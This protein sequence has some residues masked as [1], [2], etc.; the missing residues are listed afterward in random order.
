MYKGSKQFI[1]TLAITMG[2]G[3]FLAGCG[4]D[5]PTKDAENLVKAPSLMDTWTNECKESEIL[6]LS[7]RKYIEFSGNN[8]V[9]LHEFYS[10]SD[11]QSPAVALT[12]RGTFTLGEKENTGAWT[13]DSTFNTA[14]VTALNAFGQKVLETAKFCGI[15][16][17][18][19]NQ[20]MTVGNQENCP[21]KSV[22]SIEFN[23]ALVE[24]DKLYLGNSSLTN[25]VRNP[26]ERPNIERDNVMTAIDRNL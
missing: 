3:L 16:T 7:T 18:P 2:V 4:E 23:R 8:F 1:K 17:W 14:Q 12:Y 10:K 22:P 19:I 5:S 9:Q 24:S 15:A 21:V 11:C 6:E 25:G 13:V 20:A 26:N